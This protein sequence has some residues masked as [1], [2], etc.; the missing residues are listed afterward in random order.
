M[1]K[2][3]RTCG[4]VVDSNSF[5]IPLRCHMGL[6]QKL[7]RQVLATALI[8]LA[9]AGFV[10]LVVRADAVIGYR[11]ADRGGISLTTSGSADPVVAGYARI[12]PDNTSTTPS[13][14]AIFGLRQ[15][16][17]LVSETGVPATPLIKSGRLYAEVLGSV[18]TG[19]AIANPNP[20]AADIAIYFT[21]GIGT[22][23][24]ST[25]ITVPAN[26]QISRFLDQ[27]PFNLARTLRGTF[28]FSSSVPVSV[29]ALRGL[30]NEL[31]QVLLTTL[32][33]TSLDDTFSTLG[34][35]IFPHFVDGAGWTTQVILVNAGDNE[36]TGTVQFFSQGNGTVAGQ[37]QTITLN[38]QTASAFTY[39]IPRRTAVQLVTSGTSKDVLS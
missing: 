6:S 16:G 14:L 31:N 13:G 19:V 39:S 25:R 34:A 26:S 29:I 27:S 22:D 1:V 32:P 30:T 23:F 4:D 7:T 2:H 9:I 15:G 8:V 18:K 38:G 24:G 10:S 12:Q 37:P 3:R 21:D 33:V 28:T 5:H 35:T 20:Q 11:L 17:V 36:N